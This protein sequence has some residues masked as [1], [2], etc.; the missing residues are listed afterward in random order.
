GCSL[1]SS[2]REVLA[3]SG[4]HHLGPSVTHHPRHPGRCPPVLRARRPPA[5]P[6]LFPYTTLFRSVIGGTLRLSTQRGLCRLGEFGQD[7]ILDRKSTRLNSSHV[8]SSDA[9]FCLKKKKP[10]AGGQ[11]R[12]GDDVAD[13]PA[14]DD[15]GHRVDGADDR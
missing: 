9:V 3:R 15:R 5:Q 10:R 12:S 11:A 8:S 7:A 4:A 2:V 6:P 13:P 1:T 14:G